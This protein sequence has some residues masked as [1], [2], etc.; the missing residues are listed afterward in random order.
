LAIET[1]NY[2][3]DLVSANPPGTDALGQADDHIRLIKG[4]LKNTFP[5]INAVCNATPLQLNGYFVPQGAIIMWSGASAPTGWALCDGG[6]Y[7]KSD[8]SGSVQTPNLT[9]KFIIASGVKA[10]GSTGGASSSTPTITVTNVGS[11]LTQANLPSYNLTVTDNGHVHTASDSGHPHSYSAPNTS[12]QQGG[13]PGSSYTFTN[14]VGTATSSTGFANVSIASATTGIT[15]AS[16]G[17]GT[18]HTHANTA[19]SSSVS[20]VPPYYT[21]AFIYKL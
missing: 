15:V 11:T 2:I 9:D 12:N 3:S 5:N 13:A 14:F 4:V 16:G 10:V 19:T 17:S 8:G 20:T 7:S 1:A 18:A 6:T 21:L